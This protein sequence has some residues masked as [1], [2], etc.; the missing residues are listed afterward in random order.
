MQIA[1]AYVKH[2]I[3]S[4]HACMIVD[5][6]EFRKENFSKKTLEKGKNIK[7][8]TKYFLDELFLRILV[9]CKIR[10]NFS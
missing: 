9:R 5:L 6:I 3:L 7:W 10:T 2:N 1:L 4:E 8:N